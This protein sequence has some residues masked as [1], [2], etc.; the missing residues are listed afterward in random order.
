MDVLEGS[1]LAQNA[2]VGMMTAMVGAMALGLAAPSDYAFSAQVKD[3]W[4]SFPGGWVKTHQEAREELYV[5][6]AEELPEGRLDI[7]SSRR[8]PLPGW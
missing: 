1:A 4:A 5:P 3:T 6:W 8:V 7:F 2:V